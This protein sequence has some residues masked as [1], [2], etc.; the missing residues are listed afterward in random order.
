[1]P[2]VGLSAAPLTSLL[3]GQV[4]L[5]TATPTSSTGGALSYSWYF[6]GA[7]LANAGN[8]RPVNVQQ[9]GDYQV[10]IRE[11]WPTG[12]VCSNQ[13]SVVSIKAAESPNLFI[14]PTPNDGHFT[15]SYFNIE[16]VDTK[17]TITI[18][19]LKGTQ[20]FNRQFDIS[21][22]YTLIPVDLTTVNTGIYIVLVGDAKG[23]VIAFGKVHIK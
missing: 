5:L 6:N 23:K 21:G 11:S 12:L 8:T 13:S 19:D 16:G 9:V 7:S 10:K 2:S 1:L 20:V 4:T 22:A 3:P 14:F 18:Y 17:R 15:I